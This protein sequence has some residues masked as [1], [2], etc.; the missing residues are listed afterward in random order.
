[1]TNLYLSSSKINSNEATTTE[2]LLNQDE[3]N[4]SANDDQN[5]DDLNSTLEDDQNEIKINTE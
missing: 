5:E 2:L 4:D 3:R 1:M